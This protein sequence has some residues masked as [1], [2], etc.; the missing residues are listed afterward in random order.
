MYGRIYTIRVA[1]TAVSAALDFLE[2]RPAAEKPVILHKV[3]ITPTVSETNQQVQGTVRVLPATLT[4]GSAGS[5][6][7]IHPKSTHDAAAG[8]AVEAFNTS[9]ATTSGTAQYHADEGFP[10]Q[11]GFEYLPDA[12]ERPI[13]FNGEAFVVG[14]EESLAGA[15]MGGYAVVEEI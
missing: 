7:T 12:S 4:S 13:A 8:F 3:V 6:P 5:T 1:P 2:I 11:G 10:S 9:R 15:V 14:I